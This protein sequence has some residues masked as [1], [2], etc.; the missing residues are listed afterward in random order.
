[1]WDEDVTVVRIATPVEH[2]VGAV[3]VDGHHHTPR[4]GHPDVDVEH[5]GDLAGPR[6]AG[7]DDVR[8]FDRLVEAPT[9]RHPFD[10]AVTDSRVLDRA[11]CVDTRA[12]LGGVGGGGGDEPRRVDDGV[13]DPHRA[14]R[15]RAEIRHRLPGGLG[16]DLLGV[17]AYVVAGGA[18]LLE[19][20]RVV[21]GQLD[22]QSA[23]VPHT[24]AR[25]VAQ[26]RRLRTTL[27][28]PLRVRLR[29]P[30]P[31]VEQPV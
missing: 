31:A 21:V 7:V 20:L 8:R 17:D 12:R 9:D 5:V 19:V 11:V 29:V 30:C 6:P 25:D 1:M 24:V 27:S 23:C 16:V 10:P 22:E 14:F 3:V 26:H 4:G 15:L 13:V 2:R 18:F 28:G